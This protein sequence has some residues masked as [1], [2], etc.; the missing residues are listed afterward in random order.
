MYEGLI[1]FQLEIDTRIQKVADYSKKSSL[2]K[3][4]L[5]SL[6]L[7][8]E[9]GEIANKIKKHSWYSPQPLPSL[10][11][12]IT[13]ELGDVMYHVSQLATELSIPLSA[14]LESCLT[15]TKEKEEQGGRDK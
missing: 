3:M 15:K 12:D 13:E 11:K 1:E 2:E 9:A 5:N 6:A 4:T 7:V 8:G 14:I 10:R